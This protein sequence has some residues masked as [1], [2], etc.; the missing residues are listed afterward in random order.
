[1]VDAGSGSTSVETWDISVDVSKI[2]C[3]DV[4]LK[5]VRFGA[6]VF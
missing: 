5:M 3:K 4:E 1:M 2:G 6:R